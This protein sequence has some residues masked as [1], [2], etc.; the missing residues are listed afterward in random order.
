MIALI[1]LA[2]AAG[3]ARGF[4]YDPA[5]WFFH[6][7]PF[8]FLAGGGGGAVHGDVPPA[9]G[10]RASDASGDL[11]TWDPCSSVALSSALVSLP[12][13]NLPYDER[14]FNVARGGVVSCGVAGYTAV[15][16]EGTQGYVFFLL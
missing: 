9:T 2:L 16:A 3:A 15:V 14:W 6:D 12:G 5:P 10:Q 13:K 11:G 7:Y 4:T 1:L 8:R